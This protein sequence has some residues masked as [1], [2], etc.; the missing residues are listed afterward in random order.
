MEPPAPPGAPEQ[1]LAAAERIIARW[2]TGIPLSE[3]LGTA[4]GNPRLY[5]AV[6]TVFRR[7]VQLTWIID[8]LR[9][10]RVRP[11]T[12]RTLLWGIAQILYGRGLPPPIV[13]DVCVGFLRTRRRDPGGARFANAVLRRL[14]ENPEEWRR[15]LR[16]S[17]PPHV[18]LGLPKPLFLRWRR[19]WGN[20]ETA[21]LA[22]LFRSPG[23]VTVRLRA[24]APAPDPE[25][26]G[27][28][29][30]PRFDWAPET[31]F[32]NVRNP[33]AFFRSP[34]WKKGI[35]YAADP[36]A[37]LAPRML[38]PA[39]G[40]WIAD[41]CAAP[42]GKSLALHEACPNLTLVCMDRS[43]RRLQ[44]LIR[45]LRAAETPAHC[46]RADA[47]AA[48]FRPEQLDAILLDVPCS[49]TG[50]FR[51]KPDACLRFHP[52]ALDD[53]TRLQAEMLDNAASACRPGGRIAYSTCSLEPEENQTQ[54]RRFLERRPQFSLVREQ[55][56]LP[57]QLHDGAYA[58]LLAR[59]R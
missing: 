19:R 35:F 3:L 36:A 2:E 13:T 16:E 4:R 11:A 24:G 31:P 51:R 41:L 32:Y 53:I 20:A 55:T 52:R 21:R 5:N 42:G 18:R 37:L 40:E 46:L 28:L 10:K 47:R 54:V 26:L 27:L 43:P 45:N 34:A 56:L 23:P 9:R 38:A 39:P 59:N 58:A 49:N 6:L 33:E 57:T 17:A 1:T 50:V 25:A 8:Q 12:R 48:P 7:W 30:L 44:R 14:A 15:R 22:A 29:P